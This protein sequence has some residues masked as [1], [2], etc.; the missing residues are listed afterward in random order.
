M[1]GASMKS[2]AASGYEKISNMKLSRAASSMKI[3]P[4][5]SYDEELE[6]EVSSD[7]VPVLLDLLFY[8]EPR[9]VSAALGLLVRQFE[10]R[11]VL[12][13]AARKVQLLQAPLMC[14]MY[15]A[16]DEL[17]SQLSRLS[18][19][20]R[21]FGD[22]LYQAVRIMGL[23]TMHCYEEGE[24]G[25]RDDRSSRA[26][27]RSRSLAKSGSVATTRYKDHTQGLYLLLVGR[28]MAR[29]GSKSLR[30]TRSEETTPPVLVGSRLHLLG[31]VYVVQGVE[32]D[33]ID[34]AREVLAEGAPPS[35]AG[36]EEAE[37]WLF[38]EQKSAMGDPNPDIQLLLYNMSAH[39]MAIQLLG[40]P[41]SASHAS[42]AD[43]E[44]RQVLLGAYRLLKALCAGFK[45][46]Q[47]A[48]TPIIPTIVAHID[49]SLVAHDITPTGCL[50][51]IV[52]DNPTVCLSI[53]DDLIRRFIRLAAE[54][55]AP[56]FLRFLRM[57]T[58]LEQRPIPR[59][60]FFVIQGL[61][62]NAD[63][64]LLFDGEDGIARRSAMIDA[65]ELETDPRGR[66]AYHVELI[67]LMARCTDGDAPG[68]EAVARKLFSLKDILMHLSQTNLPLVLRS[69]YLAL[70]DESYF[71][72]RRPVQK[73][74]ELVALLNMF[75]TRVETFIS[76][77]L[78]TLDADYAQNQGE[79]ELTNYVLLSLTK[80]IT[81]FTERQFSVGT[82][83]EEL[84][85]AL[86]RFAKAAAELHDFIFD[87][88]EVNGLKDVLPTEPLVRCL[89][90][91]RRRGLLDASEFKAAAEAGWSEPELPSLSSPRPKTE[92]DATTTV[93]SLGATS[94]AP[95]PWHPQEGLGAFIDAFVASTNPNDKEFR[96]LVDVFLEELGSGKGEVPLKRL[97]GRMQARCCYTLCTPPSIEYMSARV[98]LL[99][100]PPHQQA[101]GAE[102]P[103]DQTVACARILRVALEH[104]F[105]PLFTAAVLQ[106]L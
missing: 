94:V 3:A 19:R 45:V 18:E 72:A 34:L 68:P 64:Q 35:M 69:N 27:S 82:N 2:A 86:T 98:P 55:F 24:E 91:L 44:V 79:S 102:T 63:A 4:A 54:N 26:P 12:E 99:T 49:Y 40:L 105:P 32:G 1:P 74:P 10:Q 92:E 21:L 78:R 16:F 25:E 81:I 6:A 96:G 75:A 76:D 60:Q 58:G 87:E 39:T 9:L 53:S 66:L 89:S 88:E 51:T 77:T 17:L 67:G 73:S 29:V 42:P 90:V 61:S 47:L 22:E 28:A 52:K 20:R 84:I 104:A 101:G 103:V 70:L 36:G 50:N 62:E 5:S 31:S 71:K 95:A 85:D 43:A 8:D 23:L 13:L 46:T 15:A 57:T 97:V 14:R 41:L 7:L 11:K 100:R 48:L 56:R 80:T 59:T 65:G 83:P 93:V 38:L 37:V 30:V 33:R 106:L